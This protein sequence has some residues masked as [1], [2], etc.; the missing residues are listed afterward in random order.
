MYRD[1]DSDYGYGYEREEYDEYEGMGYDDEEEIEEK[2]FEK[3]IQGDDDIFV[4]KKV[5]LGNIPKNE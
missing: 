1:K 5:N 3:R 4:F 2:G